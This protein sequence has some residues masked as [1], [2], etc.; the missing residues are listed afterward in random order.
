[1]KVTDDDP[2]KIGTFDVMLAHRSGNC[3]LLGGGLTVV[4]AEVAATLARLVQEEKLASRVEEKKVLVFSSHVLHL[5]LKVLAELYACR[6]EAEMFAG[7][8]KES[9]R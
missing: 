3:G 4:E 5:E 2:L 7:R 8:S 9:L 6:S 1:M